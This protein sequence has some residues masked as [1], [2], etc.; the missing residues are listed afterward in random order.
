MVSERQN[1]DMMSDVV[2]LILILGLLASGAWAV[3]Q[4]QSSHL[5]VLPAATFSASTAANGNV[6]LG[7]ISYTP[8][9]YAMLMASAS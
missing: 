1:P 4:Y 2:E 8:S 5:T 7:G 3:K 6:T 9:E